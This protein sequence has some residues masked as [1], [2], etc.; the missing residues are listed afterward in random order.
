MKDRG[1]QP[2]IVAYNARLRTMTKDRRQRNRITGK[3]ES[4]SDKVALNDAMLLQVWDKEISQDPHVRPDS[5]TIDNLLLPFIRTGR[6]GDVE[7]LLDTFV[8]RTSDTVVSEA[9][10]AFLL[11]IVDGGE[12]PSARAIF[13]TYILPTLS[14][15]VTGDSVG[16]M[17]RPTTRHFNTLIEGYRRRVQMRR[18]DKR[19]SKKERESDAE[20]AWKLYRIMSTHHG[21][22]PDAYTI[23]SMMGLCRNATELS[24]LLFEATS[25]LNVRLSSVVLRAA[26]KLVA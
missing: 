14:P 23:T 4:S 7:A 15:V 12:L 19:F 20:E 1:I 26:C 25:E 8:K 9:F 11:S 18:F 16:R 13:E 24:E 3:Y 5:Y 6:I 22:N 10:S 17:V 2:N 21:T